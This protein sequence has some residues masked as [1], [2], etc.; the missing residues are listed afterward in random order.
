MNELDKRILEL[1]DIAFNNLDDKD[2]LEDIKEKIKFLRIKENWVLPDDVNEENYFHLVNQYKML[3]E[4]IE[5]IKIALKT[6]AEQLDGNRTVFN[7][8]MENGLAF[9][10]SLLSRIYNL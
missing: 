2:F 7:K 4:N 9:A 8:G 5:Y 10:Y 6:K 1:Y 3:E